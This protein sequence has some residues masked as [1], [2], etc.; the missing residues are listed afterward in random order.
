M[1]TP[2]TK[3]NEAM[4]TSW[5]A[6]W[7]KPPP[8]RPARAWLQTD[9]QPL[10]VLV[11]HH[12]KGKAGGGHVCHHTDKPDAPSPPSLL[13]AL[14]GGGGGTRAVRWRES[15]GFWGARAPA[16]SRTPGPAVPHHRLPP[17]GSNASAFLRAR[18]L[19]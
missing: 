8:A 3:Q 7:V 14:H 1:R 6:W 5:A 2:A 18:G 19:L 15:Q 12:E 4:P 17:E 9:P 13:S 16:A 10:C 11:F